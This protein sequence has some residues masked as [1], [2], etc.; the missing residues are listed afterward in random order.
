M[1]ESTSTMTMLSIAPGSIVANR[2]EVV[3]QIGAGGMGLVYKVI[4]KHLNDE[5]VAL[6]L[7]HPHLAQDEEV[8]ARFR[9]EV[10]VA[11]SLS[12]PNIVR[13][14]D[15]GTAAQGFS[16]ISMEFVDGY[17]LSERITGKVTD[18]EGK[19]FPPLLFDDA[20]GVLYQ[21]LSGV[22]Y[23]H[24]KD[25]I[26]RD[27]KP[28][29]VMVSRGGEIKLADFGTARILG[30]TRGLTQTGQAIGTPDYMSPEQ[31]QGKTLDASSDIYALGIIAYEL[32]VGQKPFNADTSVAIAYKHLHEPI[33]PFA[34]PAKGI[35]DWFEQVVRIAT[36]KDKA[37]RYG[38]AYEF[39][40]AL[41]EQKPELSHQGTFFLTERTQF[42]RSQ[43]EKRSAKST[44]S[45]S[46]TGTA[47]GGLAVDEEGFI[48]GDSAGGQPGKVPGDSW[49]TGSYDEVKSERSIGYA[50][51]HRQKP[52]KHGTSAGVL[53]LGAAGI[54]FGLLV[55]TIRTVPAFNDYVGHT[56]GE[57]QVESDVDY[58]TLAKILGVT[59][60]SKPEQPE[61]AK[62][63]A[64]VDPTRAAER[65]ALSQELLKDLGIDDAALPA[66]PEAKPA[67]EAKSEPK[68]EPK[69]APEAKP[70]PKP[71]P[72]QTA[73]AEP[74][75][76]KAPAKQ[77]EKKPEPEAKPVE[78]AKPTPPPPP[79]EPV[80]GQV[81]F[82]S[83]GKVEHSG[84]FSVDALG[85]VSWTGQIQG[86]PKMSRSALKNVVAQEFY[87]NVFSPDSASLVAKLDARLLD[88]NDGGSVKVG[89]DL[90]GLKRADV[91]VGDYRLD[92]VHKGEVLDSV[93]LALYKASVRLS[94]PPQGSAGGSAIKI[95]RG[96]AVTGTDAQSPELPESQ[97]RLPPQS[98][99]SLPPAGF[100]APPA[101]PS[102]PPVQTFDNIPVRSEPPSHTNSL[103]PARRIDTPSSSAG[104]NWNRSSI[105]LVRDNAL[106]QANADVVASRMLEMQNQP[107]PPPP[108]EVFRG[109]IEMKS[110]GGADQQR[111]LTLSLRF[112][113]DTISGSA[114]IDGMGNFNADGKVYP[115]GL[116]INIRGESFGIRLT[117]VRRDNV[118]RGRYYIPAQNQR[119]S[120]E[121]V[122]R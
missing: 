56:L 100:D 77:P 17:S 101:Q 26:H 90:R 10:L 24:D 30:I 32:A 73:K 55:V 91:A 112:T 16:Y 66:K 86:L 103:P 76:E 67:P 104:T 57:M 37:D 63:I 121:A 12:H 53:F 116:E 25:I 117:G 59:I 96:P 11:R 95:V 27:L 69:P 14:H 105:E 122:Q 5:V 48:L 107:P 31:I 46:A 47:P 62:D 92:L 35:P 110:E 50:A 54:L 114:S 21:I 44:Q 85:G 111:G 118:M 8:F 1:V 38:S 15:M 108:A 28:A 78:T 23:A 102:L 87:V 34:N 39:A 41:A 58:S 65:E 98:E 99:P 71:E 4:D 84:T 36:A 82:R 74:A 42:F 88:S 120:W 79:P 70:E 9:N 18:K 20:L 49:T 113:D 33:P 80:R 43:N 2:Y 93:P 115:R 3:E 51:S 52:K 106:N 60:S 68:P 89:G 97:P 61:P 29:N 94:G 45:A 19:P 64:L 7:L 6:K 109:T 81:A 83:G 75:P 72:Q 13:I 40:R 119:G 22:S